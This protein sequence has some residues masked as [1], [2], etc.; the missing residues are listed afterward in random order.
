MTHTLAELGGWIVTGMLLGFSYFG[1]LWLTVRNLRHCRHPQRTM[2][3]SFFIRAA[4]LMWAIYEMTG[5]TLHAV[6]ALLA[7]LVVART[8]WAR[9]VV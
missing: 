7:G 6:L 8:A 5:G 9:A 1:G 3:E 4:V 2:L